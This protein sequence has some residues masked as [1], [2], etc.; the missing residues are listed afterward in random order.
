M[1]DAFT[2]LNPA[3]TS[4]V[5][6]GDLVRCRFPD[7][8]DYTRRTVRFCAG[9]E[10]DSHH[11]A[12]FLELVPAVPAAEQAPDTGDI[13]IDPAALAP[14]VAVDPDALWLRPERADRFD[15]AHP[16]FLTDPFEGTPVVGRLYGEALTALEIAQARHRALRAAHMADWRTR[17][18][19]R[20]RKG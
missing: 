2:T 12:V 10:I 8:L 3:W 9:T 20:R 4:S 11:G 17:R 15:T 6:F 7:L 5:A 18:A 14:T 13:F 19:R 1:L 16:G